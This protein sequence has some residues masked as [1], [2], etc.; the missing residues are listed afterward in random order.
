M[1][2][3]A[4]GAVR[5]RVSAGVEVL[6][7]HDDGRYPDAVTALIRGRDAVL[8]V[9]STLSTPADLQADLVVLTQAHEDHAVALDRPGAEVHCHAAD[10]PAL[11]SFDAMADTS[12][13][14]G[15][16]LDWWRTRLRETFRFAAVPG[17]SAFQ[18]G[19]SWD[20]GGR[21]VTAIHLPGHTP[22][23]CGLHVL[24]DDVLI[25]GDVDLTGFGPFYGD[26]GGDLAAF[27]SSLGRCETLPAA[28]IVTGHHRG[29]I[30]RREEY[31]EL[32]ARYAAV[33]DRRDQ[34]VLK[35]LAE[36]RSLDELVTARI[37]YRPHVHGPLV[38]VAERLTINRHLVSLQAAGA[39]QRCGELFQ[40]CRPWP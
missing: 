14:T 34:R 19:A 11:A 31:E 30:T 39:V 24:P 3:Q 18:D 2:P 35:L 8:Q 13:A 36:P 20:L 25:L 21:T 12:G 17:A 22:G 5:R 23:H 15:E 38:D 40:S 27:R 33:V 1:S 29:V 4:T 7:G 26:A 10:V 37:L 16:T 28:R 32:L 6:H 9:D